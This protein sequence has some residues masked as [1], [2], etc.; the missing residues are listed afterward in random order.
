[1]T[2]FIKQNKLLTIVA[3]VF[4]FGIALYTY[5]ASSGSPGVSSSGLLATSDASSA[6]SQQLLVV[7]ANLRTIRLNQAIFSDPVFLSLADFGVVISPESVGR[8]NPFLPF[9]GTSTVQ[10]AAIQTTSTVVPTVSIRQT[11][12]AK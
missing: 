6:T 1:M 10:Q 2:T 4:I 3:V 5:S 9:A 8:R 12:A 11:P 7:L